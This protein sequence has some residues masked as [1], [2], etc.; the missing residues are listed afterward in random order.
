VA[1]QK[2]LHEDDKV[3]RAQGGDVLAVSAFA[4]SSLSNP[5]DRKVLVK[6]MWESGADVIVSRPLLLTAFSSL[7]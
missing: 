6:E 1:W 5:L 2:S 3:R 4:L 7:N